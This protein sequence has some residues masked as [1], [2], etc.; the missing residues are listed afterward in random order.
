VRP[1]RE[2]L[3]ARRVLVVVVLC[4]PRCQLGDIPER[5]IEPVPVES[6]ELDRHEVVGDLAGVVRDLEV[7]YADEFP[8]W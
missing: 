8:E 3:G 5:S 4:L 2:V 6:Y 1:G 7:G